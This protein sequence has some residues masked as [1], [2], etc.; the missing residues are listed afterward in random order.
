MY[1]CNDIKNF[2]NYILQ[3]GISLQQNVGQKSFFVPFFVDQSKD[4]FTKSVVISSA[5]IDLC[6]IANST[7][8]F[9]V[10]TTI[11][12]IVESSTGIPS[13]DFIYKCYDIK[14]TVNSKNEIDYSYLSKHL[15]NF[16]K[17]KD[18]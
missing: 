18:V 5:Y 17:E 3:S 12:Q 6:S 15:D 10:N 9:K 7:N 4:A 13:S 16:L 1:T 8:M 11:P 14:N 2:A